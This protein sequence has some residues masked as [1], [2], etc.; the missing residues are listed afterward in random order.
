MLMCMMVQYNHGVR[1]GVGE[2]ESVSCSV[3]V[4]LFVNPWTVAHQTPLS[5]EFSR[6]ECWSEPVEVDTGTGQQLQP[7]SRVFKTYDSC[8]FQKGQIMREK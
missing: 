2:S 8:P 5:V 6:P 3:H 4:R 1:D 7:E